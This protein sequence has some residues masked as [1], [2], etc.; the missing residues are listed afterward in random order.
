MPPTHTIVHTATPGPVTLRVMG[1]AAREAAST[2]TFRE[3]AARLATKA[4]PRDYVAQ[5]RALYDGILHRWRYVQ[6]PE[7]WVHG[8]GR[9]AI[10]HVLGTKYNTP[11]G[12][13]ATRVDLERVPT[14][15]RGWGDCDDVATIAAA[16]VLA[17][18]MTPVFRVAR[19]N[20]GAHVS[21]LA[22]T[23]KG[24]WVSIDPVGHPDHPFGWKLDAPDVQ[25]WGLDGQPQT[26]LT[27]GAAEQ[28]EEPMTYFS[29]FDGE[30]VARV[31]QAHCTAVPY[32]DVLGPR[33]LAIPAHSARDFMAG[34][35]VDGCP[36]VDQYGGE[37]RYDADR[38][39]W[40]DSR[41]QQTPLGALPGAMGGIADGP[42]AGRASRK[43][44]RRRR[45]KRRR[46]IVKRI[47]RK[48]RGVVA[49]LMQSKWAQRLVGGALRAV[50]VPAR[51]TKAVMAVSGTILKKGGVIG[52]VKLLRRNPKAAAR[53]VARAAKD[54]IRA[55]ARLSG[56]EDI[57]PEA[58]IAEQDGRKFFAQP[59]YALAGVPG[60][61]DYGELEVSTD[62]EPGSYYRIQ[63]G[64]TLVGVAGRAYGLG[65]GRERYE[66]SKWINEVNPATVDRSNANNMYPDGRVSFRPRF[67][68]DADAAFRGER[69]RSYAV[70]W[71]PSR[72]GETPPPAVDVAD[73]GTPG[74]EDTEPV[75]PPPLPP[76]AG[77]TPPLPPPVEDPEADLPP[78]EDPPERPAPPRETTP[79]PEVDDHPEPPAEPSGGPPAEFE[80]ACLKT[81]GRPVYTP[82][83]G[84]GCVK[85]PDGTRWDDAAKWCQPIP[86]TPPPI[87]PS[88]TPPPGICRAGTVWSDAANRCIPAIPPSQPPV[89]PE[90]EPPDLPTPPPTPPTL[91]PTP[92]QGGSVNPLWLALLFL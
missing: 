62:P 13:D 72:R 10:E 87:P 49:R 5:L 38:D 90:V 15:H 30:P 35:A 52:L 51:L 47:V 63:R 9:S 22:R 23:P 21:V 12:T 32:G 86:Q 92:G 11:E 57:G 40:I 42:F 60:M 19:G 17:L 73:D 54:G 69:G 45:R 27:Y 78:V 7:E 80:A 85:C 74:I 8:T 37:F 4:P 26:A 59:V 83:T 61:Y 3:W 2:W 1:R 18:G 75:S 28:D 44:R 46:R 58:Y 43:R 14:K 31:R 64:D 68:A 50:G 16:G 55:A 25:T 36:A 24:Q 70:I 79:P 84:W 66:R 65:A 91:T 53:L 29:G 77:Q 41:L 89:V 81:G 33:A 67:A 76:D 48:V 82:Q 71:I 6:E 39:L 34:I 56:P 20:S 88:V